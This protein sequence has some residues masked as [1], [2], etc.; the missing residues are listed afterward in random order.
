M[1]EILLTPPPGDSAA[2][3]ALPRGARAI[4]MR[5]VLRALARDADV[6]VAPAEFPRPRL[7][8]REWPDGPLRFEL[9]T[10]VEGERDLV[11]GDADPAAR[12]WRD[13]SGVHVR[14]G[15]QVDRWFAYS[16]LFFG[17]LHGVRA[18]SDALVANSDLAA[19][20]EESYM[21]YTA[22]NLWSA[23]IG[24]SRWNWGPG[25]E[26][27]LLLS[28]TSAPLTGL[29]LHARLA[30]LHA[31]GFVF[32]A[33]VEP[34]RGEQLAAH[35]IEW[36]PRDGARLGISEAAR[37]KAGG[38]QGLYL[39]GVLPYA[40][41]Q[42][43]LDQDRSGAGGDTRNNVMVSCDASVRIADGSRVYGELLLDDVHARTAAFPNK[44]AWQAGWSG[45]GD[46][47]NRRI[48]W[49]TEYTWLSR[50]VY[51]SFFGRAYTAQD[52]PTGF[53]TGPDS[54]RFRA[55]V[56]LDPDTDWQL[57]LVAAR[58]ETGEEGIG[59][60]YVQGA[61]VPD[62]ATL[63]GIVQRTRTLEG[64]L[65]WW[66]AGGVD[67]SLRAGR[68]WTDNAGHVA[69]ASLRRW[70]GALAFSLVR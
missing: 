36:Q 16:H 28:R 63:A 22:G 41:V 39:A 30:P 55:R 35:R 5:R 23:Q 6:D 67:V 32:N 18:F 1:R 19:S 37:Y 52:Q 58:T 31:D 59:D 25:E 2:W 50:Y 20:S 40:M 8:A 65:R 42:K 53:P 60:P 21:G 15:V 44:Y 45:A 13:G 68:E 29:M 9:S 4:A 46:V 56:T 66:P 47:S 10:G 12:N 24:R 61:P 54:R 57:S 27:T 34:G 64:A 69:G 33:T 7:F 49:N 38:W 70:R 48:I 17:E 43:L 62:V 51:T 3:L 11:R 26:G 14:T